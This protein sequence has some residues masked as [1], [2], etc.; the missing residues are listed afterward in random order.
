MKS[1]NRETLAI[2]LY[3]VILLKQSATLFFLNKEK[4]L[5]LFDIFWCFLKVW[6]MLIQKI[7]TLLNFVVDKVA[8]K[9]W[10]YIFMNLIRNGHF[11]V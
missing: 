10:D 2:R 6:A 3:P 11:K 5:F 7:L 1:N 4:E 9:Y 8:F